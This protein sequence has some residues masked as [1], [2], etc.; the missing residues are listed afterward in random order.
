MV[1]GM[2]MECRKNVDGMQREYWCNAKEMLT[3]W[4]VNV[5]VIQRII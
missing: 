4:K 1:M 3:D 2:L 5:H